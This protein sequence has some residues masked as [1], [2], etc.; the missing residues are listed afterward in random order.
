MDNI[1]QYQ[2]LEGR[3]DLLKEVIYQLNKDFGS[4]IIEIQWNN[5]NQNPYLDFI[6]KVE[7]EVSTLLQHDKATMMSILYRIDVFESKLRVVW[8]LDPEDRGH[9]LTELILNRELQKVLTRNW[10]KQK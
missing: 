4:N 7:T 5:D 3:N 10:Y 1:Q 6:K 9:K 8:T 2:Q